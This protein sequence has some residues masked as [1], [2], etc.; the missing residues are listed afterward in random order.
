MITI[1]MVDD[2]AAIV[3][4][5]AALLDGVPDVR[6]AV[7][8]STVAGLLAAEREL[9][10][11]VLDLSLRDGSTVTDN[12]SALRGAGW[13][14]IA[15]TGGEQPHLI[16]EATRA[17]IC[18]LVRKSASIDELVRAVRAV[19]AG[20]GEFDPEWAAT[21]E[22][23]RT[24]VKSLLTD[25]EVQVLRLYASGESAARVASALF[26]S[27]DTVIDHVRRIRGKYAQQDRPVGSRVDLFRRA[28]EDGVLRLEG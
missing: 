21:L 27:E 25:R 17:G 24:F 4:G 15:F 1:G 10:V 13:P 26:I 9:D 19:A 2:H 3:H 7:A 22:A 18:G 16:R 23:D 5:V 11:A 20:E 6:V 28:V 8:A 12:V 14:V